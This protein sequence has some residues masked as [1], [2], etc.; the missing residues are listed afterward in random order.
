M[1]HTRIRL[2]QG[3]EPGVMHFRSFKFRQFAIYAAA[4]LLYPAYAFLSSGRMMVKLIDALTVTGLVFVIL[5]VVYSMIRHGDFDIAEY[6]TRRTLNK[7]DIKP[8]KAFKE[9]K[10]EERKDSMNY[11]F[12]TGLLLLLAAAVLTVF[13]Y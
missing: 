3:G 7:G 10:K 5:G 13:V 6:V 8:F 12:F 4:A 9:D 1:M 2:R 11:P